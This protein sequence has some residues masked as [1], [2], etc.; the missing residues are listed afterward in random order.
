MSEE[1]TASSVSRLDFIENQYGTGLVTFLAE[2]LHEF[3]SRQLDAANALYAFYDDCTDIPF[4]SSA[5]MASV[6]FNGR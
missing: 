2:G 1:F 4:P 6:S 3:G 5:F